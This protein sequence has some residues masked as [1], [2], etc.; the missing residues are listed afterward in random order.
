MVI[1][2]FIIGKTNNI[3]HIQFYKNEIL[4][5]LLQKILLTNRSKFTVQTILRC[6]K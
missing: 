3:I 1:I 6:T 2:S 5:K 4:K